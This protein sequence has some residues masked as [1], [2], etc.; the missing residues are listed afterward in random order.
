MSKK[1]SSKRIIPI[2]EERNIEQILVNLEKIS[3]EDI[4]TDI[5]TSM[6]IDPRWRKK[7]LFHISFILSSLSA[8]IIDAMPFEKLEV[9]KCYE[10][11]L[12]WVSTLLNRNSNDQV[13]DGSVLAISSMVKGWT[14][15][16]P[17]FRRWEEQGINLEAIEQNM[18]LSMFFHALQLECFKDM[19]KD[20]LNG[21]NKN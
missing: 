7:H 10:P 19:P 11:V 13:I 16:H 14:M 18:A 9:P 3:K 6:R 15:E 17:E 2:K 8:A 5:Q 12:R 21:N 4:D 1:K 20:G